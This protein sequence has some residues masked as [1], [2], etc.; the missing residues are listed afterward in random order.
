MSPSLIRETRET[1]GLTQA[2]FAKKHGFGHYTVYKWESGKC[3]PNDENRVKLKKIRKKA[4]KMAQEKPKDT[5]KQPETLLDKVEALQVRINENTRMLERLL[6][7]L[8]VH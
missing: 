4:L 8:G 7:G 6:S 2:A 3:R 1:L 5:Q